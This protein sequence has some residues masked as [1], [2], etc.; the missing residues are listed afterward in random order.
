MK[1]IAIGMWCLAM[2]C[3]ASAAPAAQP[4][5]ID[6][7]DRPCAKDSPELA[8]AKEK[9]AALDTQIRA[10]KPADDPTAAN[11]ALIGLAHHRCLLLARIDDDELRAEAAP[12]LVYFWGNGGKFW[13]DDQLKLA[14][15]RTLLYPPPM[16]R[17]VSME[18]RPD[19][20]M[21]SLLCPLA[22]ARCGRE[23]S[24]WWQR[25]EEYF[26]LKAM[27]PVLL[28]LNPDIVSLDWARTQVE[29]GCAADA[30]ALPDAERYATWERCARRLRK[31]GFA[32]PLG[33][34]RV[35]TSGW[36]VVRGRRGHYTYCDEVRMYSLSTGAAYISQSCSLLMMLI[37]GDGSPARNRQVAR[38]S[39]AV[40]N[41]REL[42]WMLLQLNET[43]EGPINRDQFTIP[44]GIEPA[45]GSDN[46]FLSGGAQK[47]RGV[48]SDQTTLA[49]ALMD[50]EGLARVSGKLTWPGDYLG[51]PNDHA[52]KLLQIAE[53]GFVTGCPDERPPQSLD[54]GA[55]R[56]VVSALD[57]N[58][59]ELSQAE[60][61]LVTNLHQTAR[62]NCDARS[63]R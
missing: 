40:D 5:A 60:R 45:R 27:P 58:P 63:T 41:A 9:V 50:D 32:M 39:V 30:L 2:I 33:R 19:H 62:T 59:A 47:M 14:T 51:G 10:L 57:A 7:R 23:T 49:W 55:A 22:D 44:A 16:R 31:I 12:A 35:P 48:S 54:F 18:T 1:T 25:A 21:A 37:A 53:G 34:I 11:E 8:D 43:F 56:P 26:Q 46:P 6:A 4:G 61:D 28:N 13:I 15:A 38:G 24:G 36:L 42:A 17:V 20:P 3:M 52:V 29:A